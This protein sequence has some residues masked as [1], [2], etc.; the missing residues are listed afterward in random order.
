VHKKS[1]ID[2]V[3]WASGDWCNESLYEYF[4]NHDEDSDDLEYPK[5]TLQCIALAL[6]RISI[7]LDSLL[8]TK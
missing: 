7:T 8:D 6:A 3:A 4:K 1:W 5:Q 2:G